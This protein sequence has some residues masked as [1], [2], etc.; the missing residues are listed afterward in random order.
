MQRRVSYFDVEW[1]RKDQRGRA[2]ISFDDRTFEDIGPLSQEEMTLICSLLRVGKP[3]YYD[4]ATQTFSTQSN[5]VGE[6]SA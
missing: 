4:P 1:N 6:E 2:R 3:I 5:P